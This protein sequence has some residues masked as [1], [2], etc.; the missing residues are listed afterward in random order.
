MYYVIFY[1]ETQVRLVEERTELQSKNPKFVTIT[2]TSAGTLSKVNP[3]LLLR[4]NQQLK[5][6]VSDSS[7]SFTDDGITYSAFKL[8]FF[9]DKEYQDEFITTQQNDAYEVQSSGRMGI[10][11]DAIVT[12]SITEDIPSLLFYKF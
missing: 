12:L 5:F 6:D 10:D 3:P 8:Q 9:R 7:L 1:D 4:K 11:S 2:S